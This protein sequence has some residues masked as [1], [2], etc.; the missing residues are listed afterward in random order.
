MYSGM[1]PLV[2]LVLTDPLGLSYSQVGLVSMAFTVASSVSQPFF[3]WLGDRHSNRLIAVLG[4]A[5]IAVTMGIMRFADSFTLLMILAPIAGLGSGA[6]H[7][8]G[9]A[10]ASQTP[11]QRRGSA[12]SIFMLGGNSGYAFGPLL[13]SAVFA[14]AGDQMPQTFALLGLGQAALVYWALAGQQ[15]AQAAGKARPVSSV[16]RA[17]VAVII[18]LTLVIFFRSWVQTSVVTFVP[19]VYKA[20]GYST[21]FAGNVLFSILMPLAIGGLIGGTLSDRIG[22]RRVLIASTALIGPALWGLLNS[23]GWSTFVWGAFLGLASGASLP[24]TLVM[25]QGL[26]PRG[27]GMMS[28]FV[29]GFTFIAGAVGVSANG[30]AADYIGLMPTMLSNALLPLLAAG[31]ALLLPDDRPAKLDIKSSTLEIGD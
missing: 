9:A 12:M 27:P 1:L 30:I 3:G 17:A 18:T 20:L 29:L 21:T 13:G 7:P 11:A 22:R 31:L 24:V 28:G 8:Q 26:I 4:V 10:L 14:V 15:R 5:A 6:F 19:Q 23:S 16:K 25:A 2:I